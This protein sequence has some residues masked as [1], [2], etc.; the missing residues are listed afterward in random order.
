MKQTILA[1]SV[2]LLLTGLVS[3][4]PVHGEHEVLSRRGSRSV[5][6]FCCDFS[7][8]P[9]MANMES[10][11]H[12]CDVT[13]A[14]DRHPHLR[15]LGPGS[16]LSLRFTL[17]DTPVAAVLEVVHLASAGPDGEGI[18]PVTVSVNGRPVV[19]DWNVGATTFTETRW[20]VGEKLRP[21]ENEIEWTA[22]EIRTHYWLR[23]VRLYVE[24]DRPVE[25]AFPALEVGD[26]L[27]LETRFS[28]CSYN[29]LATVLDHF[30]GIEGWAEDR[31]AFE[32]G[33]FVAALRR[34]GLEPYY[35]WAP[36]TSYMVQSGRLR[37]AGQTVNDL[38]AERFALRTEEVP[39]PQGREMLV[40]YRPGE[41]GR[42]VEELLSRLEEGPV[43]LWTPYAAAMEGGEDGWR[44][45]PLRGAGH[46]CRAVPPEC[47]AQ[48]RREPGGGRGQGLRQLAA[49]RGL[50]GPAGDGRRHRRR[51]VGV[52]PGRACGREDI[53]RRWPA[54]G[55]SG[56]VP[57]R[58]PQA[59]NEMAARSW[60]RMRGGRVAGPGAGTDASGVS[61]A[62]ASGPGSS[63][64]RPCMRAAPPSR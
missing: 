21:G 22:G 14:H 5:V 62:S 17:P 63:A 64:A 45:C 18:A 15:L 57:R 6:A 23:A 32:D 55:G 26:E 1:H 51:H 10:S 41:K 12:G 31:A 8:F 2:L 59:M 9:A 46:G 13:V 24:F 16:H 58:L 3:A 60:V 44:P 33:Q 53:A 37:W 43:I 35:G 52:D 30:Y 39:Q 56:R 38:A 29:A 27:F 49:G 40:H 50:R 20:P 61:P 19:R 48:R 54:W 36:W 25:V 4:Q 7:H 42:L 34:F 47:H 28:Q 11:H